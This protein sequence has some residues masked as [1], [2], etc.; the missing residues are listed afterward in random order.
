MRIAV[1]VAGSRVSLI[2][3]DSGPGIAPEDRAKLFDRFH[4]ATDE[5]NGAGLGLAIADSVVRATGGE[6]RVGQADL[7]GAHMEVRWHRSPGARGPEDV[8]QPPEPSVLEGTPKTTSVAG[9]TL[10]T[11]LT[12]RLDPTGR[13][14]HR[15]PSCWRKQSRRIL[16]N[17][18][19]C[20][21]VQRVQD[22]SSRTGT[23]SIRCHGVGRSERG[24][25]CHRTRIFDR[26]LDLVKVDFAPRIVTPRVPGSCSPP[27]SP[28]S[29]RWSLTPP[30]WR[31]AKQCFPPPKA[32]CTSGSAITPS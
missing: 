28:W 27:W 8:R 26:T 10:P 5:G 29:G 31:S 9:R 6:W 19:R 2:V 1:T 17:V 14:G 25:Q 7:G 24:E 12:N 20:H 3:D 32:T 23:S 16:E 30:W 15:P 11:R 13:S 21:R 4:R 22:N 18:R